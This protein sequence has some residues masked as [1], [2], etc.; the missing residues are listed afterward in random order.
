MSSKMPGALDPQFAEY[1]AIAQDAINQNLAPI[2]FDI[3]LAMAEGFATLADRARK[4]GI[5]DELAQSFADEIF[6]LLGQTFPNSP[7]KESDSSPPK[8]ERQLN[9]IA[10]LRNKP[11]DYEQKKKE[12]TDKSIA[13]LSTEVDRNRTSEEMSKKIEEVKKRYLEL[14]AAC[15]NNKKDSKLNKQKTE[16]KKELDDLILEAGNINAQSRYFAFKEKFMEKIYNPA[17]KEQWVKGYDIH[18]MAFLIQTDR[19]IKKMD[20]LYSKRNALD[21]VGPVLRSNPNAPQTKLTQFFRGKIQKKVEEHINNEMGPEQAYIQQ[22]IEGLKATN[23]MTPLKPVLEALPEQ[24]L[25][26]W[27]SST[28]GGYITGIKNSIYSKSEST[29]NKLVIAGALLSAVFFTHTDTE[30][31]DK[32]KSIRDGIQNARLVLATCTSEVFDLA[33]DNLSFILSVH[34]SYSKVINENLK[35]MADFRKVLREFGMTEEPEKRIRIYHQI[36]QFLR[37]LSA[38]PMDEIKDDHPS[39]KSFLALVHGAV[40]KIR[41]MEYKLNLAIEGQESLFRKP[42]PYR[43]LSAQS[44]ETRQSPTQTSTVQSRVTEVIQEKVEASAIE[45]LERDLDNQMDCL[46]L[47]NEKFIESLSPNDLD[48]RFGIEK[49]PQ[50]SGSFLIS[51]GAKTAA[52]PTNRTEE[53]EPQKPT[54]PTSKKQKP[55]G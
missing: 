2:Q 52:K 37:E 20:S 55:Q 36:F 25:F 9:F 26:Q 23:P 24:S 32:L 4:S 45:V 6:L 38:I 51:K 49:E 29:K 54:V 31:K 14:E 46:R 35:K 21:M 12:F 16:A 11:K 42:E 10:N 39:L 41:T 22:I 33:I 34:P 15:E 28:V 5:I 48:N 27:A 43:T 44:R 7:S 50:Q 40:E 1:A 18:T 13:F 8:C 3:L 17:F 53:P 30:P 47:F 19:L